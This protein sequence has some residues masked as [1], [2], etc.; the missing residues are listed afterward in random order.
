MPGQIKID[1]GSGNYTILTNGGSLGSDKTITIPNETGTVA[2][3]NSTDLGG[4]VKLGSYT[5]NNDADID[6]DVLDENTYSGYKLVAK[7][8]KTANDNTNLRAG[9][10]ASGSDVLTTNS[11]LRAAWYMNTASSG[12]TASSSSRTGFFEVSFNQGNDTG[13]LMQAVVDV[14]PHG[15]QKLWNSVN[16]Y[17]TNS[18]AQLAAHIV[19]ILRNDT[20]VDG[21]RF[22]AGSGNVT[23]GSIEIWGYKK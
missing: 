8:I 16:Q 2:L 4:L 12:I 5:F 17:E 22:Y 1:D 23:S 19:S 9:F 18:G 13:E 20:T 21:L 3:D 7:D 15:T 11:Y 6:A 14:F 10:R